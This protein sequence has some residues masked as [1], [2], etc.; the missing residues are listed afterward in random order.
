MK[1]RVA[2]TAT[3]ASLGAALILFILTDFETYN[4]TRALV[5]ANSARARLTTSLEDL[6]AMMSALKDGEAA[7]RGFIITGRED[8]LEPLRRGIPTVREK[9]R[10]V[11]TFGLA[12]STDLD[13]LERLVERKIEFL[14]KSIRARANSGFPDAAAIVRTGEGKLLMDLVRKEA[15]VLEG[16]YNRELREREA[17]A[18][19]QDRRTTIVALM[20]SLLALLLVAASVVLAARDSARRASA[21]RA[22]AAEH[23]K[24]AA[25]IASVP[26]GL[27]LLDRSGRMVLQNTA[28]E[29]LLKLPP[30]AT[31]PEARRR[32][33]RMLD[34]DG[35]EIPYDHWPTN[36][37]V[38]GH[39]VVGREVLVERPDAT[40]IPL[41]INA[42]PLRGADGELLGAVAGF[43]DITHIFEVGRLKDEFVSTVSHELR[44]PLTSIKGSL[45]LV[46]ADP[47]SVPDT[48]YHE[49]LTVALTNTERLVRLIN[50][51][52]DIS[53]IDAGRLILIR[54]AVAP[55]ELVRQSIA[56]VAQAPAG[57]TITATVS[58]GVP[59]VFADPDRILQALVN[60]LSNALK[61]APAGTAVEVDVASD[62]AHFVR[63][64]VSAR[65]GDSGRQNEPP[66]PAIPAARRIDDPS[67]AGHRPGPRHHESPGRRTRG[68][69]RGHLDRRPGIDVLIHPSCSRGERRRPALRSAAVPRK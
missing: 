42:A 31:P 1:P 35:R 22:L 21:E 5:E 55:A 67:G 4:S 61:F 45:Q 68:Q 66:L 15:E 47:D 57:V 20:S 41:I 17:A 44:T 60:L 48:E 33:Y 36:L 27:V 53:K 49:L 63:F 25:T 23:S 69:D 58:E 16:L 30:A 50:D 37:A 59:D 46:L 40:T 54:T 10:A 2:G 32:I 14:E 3:V 13:R 24:L 9:L 39:R 38:A 6:R 7:Q 62:G 28:A 8:F 12:P 51:I 65:A 11:R 43:Q 29:E 18:E 19:R 26:Y 34:R 64:S 56:A 52:L